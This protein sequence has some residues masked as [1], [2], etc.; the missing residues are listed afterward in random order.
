MALHL[1]QG[2]VTPPM[3]AGTVSAEP[4]AVH[5]KLMTG[6]ELVMTLEAESA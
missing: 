6:V 1:G 2:P 3:C 4:Q 5:W